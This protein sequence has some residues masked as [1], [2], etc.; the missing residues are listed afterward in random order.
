[1]SFFA[2]FGGDYKI[3]DT[4]YTSY[5]VVYTCTSYLTAGVVA[6]PNYS[7]VLV[8]SPIEEGSAAYTS[9]M[10]TVSS[11]Y[12]AKVPDY[13]HLTEMRTTK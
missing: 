1:M 4:D 10:N 8:R 11:I 12:A 9:V 2:G 6:T 3:L 7:W 13:D 5:V